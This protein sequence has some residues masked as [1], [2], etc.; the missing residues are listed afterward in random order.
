MSIVTTT[1]TRQTK[2]FFP[3]MI[4][5]PSSRLEVLQ[6]YRSSRACR[7]L[8]HIA[9][10]IRTQRQDI[11]RLLADFVKDVNGFR[12][13]MKRTGAIIVGDFATCFFTGEAPTNI[14]RNSLDLALPNMN[15][16]SCESWI[17]LLKGDIVASG[18]GC[19][20]NFIDARVCHRQ[21]KHIITEITRLIFRS[22]YEL[23]TPATAHNIYSEFCSPFPIHRH[24]AYRW[25]LPPIFIAT[26]SS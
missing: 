11:N 5:L 4:D 10:D 25:F 8:R 16:G 1:S 21:R 13:F 19:S 17:S 3:M 15:M 7:H 6:L 20:N 24:K 2:L 22:T 12:L 26:S 18:N 9:E 23:E 14:Y